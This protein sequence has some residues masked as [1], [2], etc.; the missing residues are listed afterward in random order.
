MTSRLLAPCLAAAALLPAARALETELH[1]GGRVVSDRV[2][3]QLRPQNGPRAAAHWQRLL[4]LP[5]GVVLERDGFAQWRADAADSTLD[6]GRFFVVQLRGK[7]S[8][9]EA[10]AHLR[11][12]PEV[13]VAEPDGVARTGSFRPNDPDYSREWHHERLGT[14]EAWAFTRGATNL[15]VAVVD[16]GIAPTAEFGERLLPGRNFVHNNADTSDLDGHG[17][18]CA[19]IIGCTGQ[20]G[21]LGAGFDWNCRLLPVK[22]ITGSLGSYAAMAAGIDYAV[23]QGARV[24][25]LS[26]GGDNDSAILGDAVRRAVAAGVIFVTITHNDSR[27]IITFPGRMPESITVGASTR[28]DFRAPYSN[29]GPRVDL[30]APG[31]DVYSINTSGNAQPGGATSA[32]APQVSGAAALLLSL[33]PTLR[34]EDVRTILRAAAA[35]DLG[36]PNDTPGFDEFHG[37]GRLDV[38]EAVAIARAQVG[39]PPPA[40]RLVNVSTRAPVGRGDE[41]LIGGLVVRGSG[42]KRFLFRALGP[43]LAARG[44]ANALA[45]PSLEI[46]DAGGRSLGGNDQWQSAQ[47]GEITAS[48]FAP[49][50]PRE[51][52]AIVTLPPGAYTAVV[53]GVGETTGVGLVEAYELAADEEPRFINL[54]TR[55]RVSSGD[56]V[57]IA[58]LVLTGTAPRRVLL[59]CLGPSL[60]PAGV[61]NAIDR[62][63][64]EIVEGS[65]VFRTNAGWTAASDRAEIEATGL[66]PADTAE[67]ALIATLAPGAYTAIV[68]PAAGSAGGVALVEVYDL[69]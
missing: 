11:A 1:E 10:L 48:G 26:A 18:M 43:S 21:R 40:P 61:G 41:V 60:R 58:G 62:A 16:T 52:A 63:T 59:R 37:A 28:N 5:D 55:G 31:E 9:A 38:A 56:D 13:A 34:Q 33:R 15:V 19:G 2:L 17:T 66:A 45:D 20:N 49:T 30:L 7:L 67:C 54:S 51:A 50:D 44:V 46:F 53:R 4:R 27:N 64:L 14:P 57:M 6:P 42:P 32:A 69:E 65:R 25:N 39:L 29:W 47:A 68:R 36:E 24:I 12:Q 8:L 3:V 23:A 22:V 35:D